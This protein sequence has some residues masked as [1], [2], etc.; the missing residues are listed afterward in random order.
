MSFFL[1]K[2]ILAYILL[3]AAVI[4]ATSMLSIMGKTEKETDLKAKRTAHKISGWLFLLMLFPLLYM[5]MKHWVKLGDQASLRSV[6]HAVLALGLIII[7][8][9]KTAI[10]KLYKK[11]LRFAPSLGMAIFCLTFVVFS[12]SAVYYSTK[13]LIAPPA[14]P[15]QTGA[16]PFGLDGDTGIGASLFEASCLSCHFPD[17]EENKFAPGLKGL[18]GK[19]TLP[20]SGRPATVENVIRQLIEPAMSMPSFNYFSKKEIADLISYLKTL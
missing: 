8:L 7:V 14:S 11:F 1:V 9:L 19:E 18:F 20:Y 4:S 15:E 3:A 2:S 6:F 16:E 10:V 17:S 5:G 12:I 13:T